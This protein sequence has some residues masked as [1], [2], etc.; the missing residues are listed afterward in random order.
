M[1][2]QNLGTCK[3]EM[4]QYWVGSLYQYFDAGFLDDSKKNNLEQLSGK[5]VFKS[6]NGLYNRLL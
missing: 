2:L 3:L 5:Q 4:L 1:M 6:E